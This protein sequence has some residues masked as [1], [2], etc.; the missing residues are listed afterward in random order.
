MAVTVFVGR[1]M[2]PAVVITPI[3][4]VA[5]SKSKNFCWSFIDVSSNPIE[6]LD[7]FYCCMRLKFQGLSC[8]RAL[9]S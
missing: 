7:E 6:Y 2:S 4:L 9:Q 8:R 3:F 1:I 5:L